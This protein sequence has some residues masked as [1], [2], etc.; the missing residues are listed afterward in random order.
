MNWDKPVLTDSGGFQ[1][2]SLGPLRKITEEGVKFSSYLDGSEQYFTPESVMK[3][4][5]DIGADI[6][7]AF[8]ECLKYPSDYEETKLSMERTT[9]W[10]K[11]CKDAHV[12]DQA[13]FGITQGGFYEDLR[14]KSTQDLIE[15]DFP[16]YAI[17]RNKCRGTKR[18][19]L[20]N[21]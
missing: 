16:G 2:F 1:V 17:R 19:I 15:M 11:R 21:T 20:K 12:T 13:L 18:R 5:E 10:A 14:L 9:R 3:T 7:M 6:I 8:D 4:E